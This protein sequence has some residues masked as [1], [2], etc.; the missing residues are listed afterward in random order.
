MEDHEVEVTPDITVHQHQDE[1]D[2]RV[3]QQAI[4]HAVGRVQHGAHLV[5]QGQGDPFLGRIFF[6]VWGARGRRQH[7]WTAGL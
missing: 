2:G 4:A 1:P 3:E 7:R 6:G 5:R